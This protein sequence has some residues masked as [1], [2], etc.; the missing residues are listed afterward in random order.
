M[1][2]RFSIERVRH[3]AP[4][5]RYRRLF[6]TTR[7]GAFS[8]LP[9]R[10]IRFGF[11]RVPTNGTPH[12]FKFN[13]RPAAHLRSTYPIESR[14]VPPLRDFNGRPIFLNNIMK[15]N[16]SNVSRRF[17]FQRGNRPLTVF[18]RRRVYRLRWRRCNDSGVLCCFY[19]PATGTVDQ[20][21]S[22]PS[23]RSHVRAKCDGTLRSLCRV[24]EGLSSGRQRRIVTQIHT[25]KCQ[26]RRLRF[27]RCTPASAVQRLFM[28]VRNRTRDVPCFVLSGRY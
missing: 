14:R 8:S 19:N 22:F 26:I 3:Y 28:Q 1:N 4:F 10:L 13:V 7:R 25:G 9:V 11:R 23:V 2:F 24:N 18:R 17:T 20:L 27:C 16:I 15:V 5:S 12:E 21:G 6:T